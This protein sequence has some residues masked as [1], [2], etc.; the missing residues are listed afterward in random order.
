MEKHRRCFYVGDGHGVGINRLW[1]A[2]CGRERKRGGDAAQII[3]LGRGAVGQAAASPSGVFIM[4]GCGG[5]C[6]NMQGS[7]PCSRGGVRREDQ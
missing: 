7:L 4:L 5:A 6:G 3:I 2:G 1:C